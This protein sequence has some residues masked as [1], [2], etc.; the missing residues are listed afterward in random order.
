MESS[1]TERSSLDMRATR[2]R[3]KRR[4]SLSSSQLPSPPTSDRNPNASWLCMEEHRLLSKHCNDLCISCRGLK[5]DALLKEKGLV[6]FMSKAR[7]RATS[8]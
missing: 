5:I 4:K 1:G 3:R 2:S 6:W 8:I 7:Y